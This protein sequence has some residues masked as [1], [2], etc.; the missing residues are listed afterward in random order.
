MDDPQGAS[1]TTG[2]IFRGQ[3]L[4]NALNAADFASANDAE[5]L[6][7]KGIVNIFTADSM[8]SASQ[9]LLSKPM[10]T[11]KVDFTRDSNS[12]ISTLLKRR[13]THPGILHYYI[14]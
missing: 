12:L 7:I 13:A 11:M 8:E 3:A 9:L 4:G 5:H 10:S 14:T 1:H 6:A 2:S